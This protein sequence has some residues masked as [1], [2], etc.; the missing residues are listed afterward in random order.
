MKPWPFCHLWSEVSTGYCRSRSGSSCTSKPS[1]SPPKH[2]SYATLQDISGGRVEGDIVAEAQSSGEHCSRLDG[3]LPQTATFTFQLPEPVNTTMFGKSILAA[4]KDL[5]TRPSQ[6]N[7]KCPFQRRTGG[8]LRPETQRRSPGKMEAEMGTM[9]A[10]PRSARRWRE[11]GRD[12]LRAS[13]RNQ[14]TVREYISIV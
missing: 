8:D 4:V 6:S 9:P 3:G 1:P 14:R 7:G 11:L 13:R 5:E 10:E 2:T 12:S